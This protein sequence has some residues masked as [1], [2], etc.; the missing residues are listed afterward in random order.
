MVFSPFWTNMFAIKCHAKK[1]IKKITNFWK[2]VHS[3]K[4]IFYENLQFLVR[5]I[6]IK[7][8]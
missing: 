6:I 1:I 7:N 4:F 5:V 2:K 8:H 3:L